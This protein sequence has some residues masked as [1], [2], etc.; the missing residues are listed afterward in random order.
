MRSDGREIVYG[1][2][3]LQVVILVH[4]VDEQIRLFLYL[5]ILSLV[6]FL[7]DLFLVGLEVRQRMFVRV[8][9]AFL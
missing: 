9:S 2:I 8:F 5:D 1:G 7:F 4:G 3:N 6:G